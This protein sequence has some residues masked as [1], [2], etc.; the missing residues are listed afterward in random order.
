MHATQNILRERSILE[1]LSH[2]LIVNLRFA[3]QDDE[4]LFMVLDLMMG[5]DLRFHLDQ[6]GGFREEVVKVWAAEVVCSV[7]YLHKHGIVHRD[8]KPDNSKH[9]AFLLLLGLHLVLLVIHGTLLTHTKTTPFCVY[10]FSLSAVL[11]DSQ[12]HAH[13]TDFNIAVRYSTRKILTSHSGTLAYMAPE[14]F[15]DSGYSWQIDWWSF[16][17]ILYELYFGKRP[18]KGKDNDSLKEAICTEPLIFPTQNHAISKAA[19][20][21]SPEFISLLS[22]LLNRDPSQRLGCGLTG[23]QEIKQHPWF[24]FISNKIDGSGQAKTG[25][26][27]HLDPWSLVESKSLKPLFVPD[28]NAANFDAAH[29]LEELLLEEYP[30]TYRPRKN[31]NNPN[32]ISKGGAVVLAGASGKVDYSVYYN[33]YGSSS[34]VNAGA[35]NT[36]TPTGTTGTTGTTTTSTSTAAM[37]N[38]WGPHA[39]QLNAGYR[40]HHHHPHHQLQPTSYQNQS[41]L[42]SLTPSYSHPNLVEAAISAAASSSSTPSSSPSKSNP[43]STTIQMKRTKSLTAKISGNNLINTLNTKHHQPQQKANNSSKRP[44][45]RESQNSANNILLSTSSSSSSSS[46]SL[47]M[48]N[49]GFGHQRDRELTSSPTF[50]SNNMN[51]ASH[52]LPSS[53]PSTSSVLKRTQSNNNNGFASIGSNPVTNNNSPNHSQ[54]HQNHHHQNHQN[55]IQIQNQQYLQQHHPSHILPQPYQQQQ[56]YDTP[57]STPQHSGLH[58]SNNT[59]AINNITNNNYNNNNIPSPQGSPTPK[60]LN[61]S[62]TGILNQ[63]QQ[64]QH[65]QPQSVVNGQGHALPMHHPHHPQRQHQ[66]YQYYQKD[67]TSQPQTNTATPSP[68]PPPPQTQNHHPHQQQQNQQTPSPPPPPVLEPSEANLQFFYSAISHLPSKE[69]HAA[70]LQFLEDHFLNFNSRFQYQQ[71]QQQ[72]RLQ[73][74]THIQTNTNTATNTTTN[75]A[76]NTNTGTANNVG[77]IEGKEEGS[78]GVTMMM[79]PPIPAATATSKKNGAVMMGVQQKTPTSPQ[80]TNGAMFI[81]DGAQQQTQQ[82]Q[83]QHQHHQQVPNPPPPAATSPV[84]T[85]PFSYP[86]NHHHHHQQQQQQHQQHQQHQTHLHHVQQQQHPISHHHTHHTHHTHTH[87]YNQKQNRN[88]HHHHHHHNHHTHHNHHNHHQH[89][90]TPP[91]QK[92]SFSLPNLNTPPT[93]TSSQNNKNNINNINNPASNPSLLTFNPNS[94][95]NPT[96]SAMSAMTLG[97]VA[98]QQQGKSSGW[99]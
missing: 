38:G 31:Q 10:L 7:E 89:Q 27:N 53:S 97:V 90:P 26:S 34:G 22:C 82:I 14:I 73:S 83:H 87:H 46:S 51:I 24:Q 50:T 11:L 54:F 15:S 18:F 62:E 85:H 99:R 60:S 9:S 64:Q 12:G 19:L 68:P 25:T 81:N 23:A 35:G 93:T 49:N 65:Q 37:M 84:S 13:L 42:A 39:S 69:R 30:L 74:L 45:R 4:N 55:Q 58:Q 28:E 20:T 5:G 32:K 40:Q 78:S 75:T 94:N 2:P 76:N 56:M 72:L 79:S 43:N 59:T 63:Q 17:I 47:S 66:N 57:P 33:Y 21:T 95:F 67:P 98:Q 88:H 96:F 44:S 70:E 16:G 71:Q 1:E 91:K 8:L 48:S 77:V 36:A 6:V 3:F 92:S 86:V 29:D 52:V 80:M 41:P 61:N